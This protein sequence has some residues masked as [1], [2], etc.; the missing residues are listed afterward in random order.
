MSTSRATDDVGERGAVAARAWDQPLWASLPRE[1]APV[2]REALI[3]E[4]WHLA[5]EHSCEDWDSHLHRRANP[6]RYKVG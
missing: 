1:V 4:T 6:Q 3:T 5:N 2:A